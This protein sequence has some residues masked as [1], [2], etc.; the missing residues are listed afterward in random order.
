M[1]NYNGLPFVED[2]LRS[3]EEDGQPGSRTIVVD[4]GS[5]DG[6]A[7]R[8]RE[9]FPDLL[10]IANQRN[11]YF[12]FGA[13]QGLGLALSRRAE[14][15]FL[16]NNDAQVAPG[17]LERLT[18]F[19]ADQ[20]RAG[21]C[22]PLLVFQSAPETIASAGGGLSGAGKAWDLDRGTRVDPAR[23]E[24]EAV[25]AVSGGAMF[26]R[27][28]ALRRTGLFF[29][30]FKMY[31]EDMD[32]SLRL[33]ERGWTTHLVPQARVVHAVSRSVDQNPRVD[34][35]FLC[36]RNA[37]WLAL[38]NYPP[39]KALA[40]LLMNTIT[41]LKGAAVGL[42]DGRP[43]RAWRLTAALTVGLLSYAV[44]WPSGRAERIIR[45][46]SY[47]FADLIDWE[48]DEPPARLPRPVPPDREG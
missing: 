34:R 39:G 16:L 40:A 42:R 18:G 31:F 37:H 26:L 22:Q 41:S 25:L 2:C 15:V 44:L 19:M 28:Q 33:R 21:A 14:Y 29:S 8:L 1:V 10:L 23:Q 5:R 7:R 13:N 3:L 17:S 32:L 46:R 35:R 9:L 45:K 6:S 38:R 48:L 24:P 43:G 4:N 11:R 27:A 20:P 36:E 30:P 12:A 47:P